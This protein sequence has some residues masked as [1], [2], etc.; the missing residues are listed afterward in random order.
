[1]KISEFINT[2]KKLEDTTSSATT[3]SAI[4]GD[5]TQDIVPHDIVPEQFEGTIEEH[6]DHSAITEGVSQI[7]RRAKKGT[8]SKGFRCSSGPRKGRIV[9]KP[10]TCFAKTDPVKGAK[11]RK[12]RLQKAG[13]AGK[14]MA[15]TKRSG[16]GS[17]R[18]KGAQIKKKSQKGKSTAPRTKARPMVK[19]RVLK[20]KKR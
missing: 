15:Q 9:A 11:I 13:I 17:V 4:Q 20:P 10:G 19:S 16:A 12:K 5:Q 1:M 14:K 18:L 8:V 7:L 2:P 6:P 3:S